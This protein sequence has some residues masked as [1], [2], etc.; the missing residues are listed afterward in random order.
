MESNGKTRAGSSVVIYDE[1]KDYLYGY[2]IWADERV[3]TRWRKD[4]Y[5]WK[6]Q[7]EP[8]STSIDLVEYRGNKLAI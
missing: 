7:S 6:D 8:R 1:D 3:Q 5:F 2:Y 4:G